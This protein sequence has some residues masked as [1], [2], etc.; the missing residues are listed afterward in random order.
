VWEIENIQT[1]FRL[2]INTLVAQY[3]RELEKL[4]TLF[5]EES[6]PAPPAKF[7]VGTRIFPTAEWN[8]SRH[9][10]RRRWKTI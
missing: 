10:D 1:N 4:L 6:H 7:V 3:F 8:F 5:F 2:Q 9:F